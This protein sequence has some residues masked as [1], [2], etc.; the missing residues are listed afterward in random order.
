[1]LREFHVS[2]ADRWRASF[3]WGGGHTAATDPTRRGWR[4]KVLAKRSGGTVALFGRAGIKGCFVA[5]PLSGGY[6]VHFYEDLSPE[7]REAAFFGPEPAAA[8]YFRIVS[9]ESGWA[10]EPIRLVE[11][12]QQ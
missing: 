9:G 7:E 1:M 5:V 8:D 3:P 4:M 10:L 11:S 12:A 2:P 6:D